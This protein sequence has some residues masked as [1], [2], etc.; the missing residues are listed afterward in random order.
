MLVCHCHKVTDRQ[1]KGCVRAGARTLRAV[2]RSC[3]AGTG[4]GG[5]RQ[6]LVELMDQDANESGA[7]PLLPVL[8]Y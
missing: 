5:C 4:C 3:R 7:S 1:I 8:T 2:A 6:A